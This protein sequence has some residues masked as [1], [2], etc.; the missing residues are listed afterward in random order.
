MCPH[1]PK[2]KKLDR[3][4]IFLSKSLKNS[5]KMT[6]PNKSTGSSDRNSRYH[7][8]KTIFKLGKKERMSTIL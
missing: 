3:E 5:K 2:I 1:T 4:R 8:L 6:L 7:I